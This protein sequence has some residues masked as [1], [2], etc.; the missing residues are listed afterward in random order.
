MGKILWKR[1]DYSNSC[2][3]LEVDVWAM[4]NGF[5]GRWWWMTADKGGR[6]LWWWAVG[7]SGGGR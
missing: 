6:W 4:T 2:S 1:Y 7:D 3:V 5:D